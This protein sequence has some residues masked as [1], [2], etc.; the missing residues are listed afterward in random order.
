MGSWHTEQHIHKVS[1]VW[2]SSGLEKQMCKYVFFY[3]FYLLNWTL[4]CLEKLH[5]SVQSTG[6][7]LPFNIHIWLCLHN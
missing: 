2:P 7:Y 3:F 5:P 4:K 6:I 1:P